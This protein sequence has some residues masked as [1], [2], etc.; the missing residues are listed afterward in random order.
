MQPQA[1]FGGPGQVPS[2]VY[3]SFSAE[4]QPHTTESLLG[5]LAECA[6]KGVK[7]VHL[8]LST[9][10][11]SVMN[12]INLYNVMRAIPFHLFLAGRTRYACPHSTFMF[13]GVGLDVVTPTRLEEKSLREHLD[14]VRADHKR[15]GSI[16]AERTKISED[17]VTELF[18]EMKTKDAAFAAS[19]G[20]VHEVRDVQI[21]EGSPVLQLVLQ[22]KSA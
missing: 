18:L 8:M 4:I 3:I 2:I 9:P 15:I 6:S 1:P 16:I 11:G 21:P 12:G 19:C 22:R 5:L 14:A 20:I 13:H 10:G 17:A 7:T